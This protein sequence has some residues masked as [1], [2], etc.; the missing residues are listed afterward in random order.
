[1]DLEVIEHVAQRNF[2]LARTTA[3]DGYRQSIADSGEAPA[4]GGVSNASPFLDSLMDKG[5]TRYG[6]NF[7]SDRS[8]IGSGETG[9]LMG[10]NGAKV[11]VIQ[12][13]PLYHTTGEVLDM[14]STPGLERM[15]RFLAFFVREVGKAPLNAINPSR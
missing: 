9:G 13:P 7:I 11:T 2:S 8:T 3:E 5:V 12:A 15:A 6:V 14:I 10:I 4:Y 1:M